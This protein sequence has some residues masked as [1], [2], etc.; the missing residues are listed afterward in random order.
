MCDAELG[1]LFEAD[2][3]EH[4]NQAHVVEAAIKQRGGG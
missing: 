4:A 1:D 3:V 2:I